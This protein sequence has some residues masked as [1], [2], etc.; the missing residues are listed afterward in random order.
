VV[1]L[2]TIET[3]GGSTFNGCTSLKNVTLSESVKYIGSRAFFLCEELE[4]VVFKG[5]E[6]YID[7]EAFEHS[8]LL[9]TA[10]GLGS[11]CNIEY[12]WKDKVNNTGLNG[13]DNITTLKI[14]ELTQ[15]NTIFKLRRQSFVTRRN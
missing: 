15:S 10:G 3:I 11:G 6:I 1:V 4:K 7:Y 12:G 14:P 13:F 8:T 5:D 2:G 9:K